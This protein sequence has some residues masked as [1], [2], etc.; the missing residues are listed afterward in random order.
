YVWNAIASNL[1]AS[2][3][4]LPSI[5]S[6]IEGCLRFVDKVKHGLG[7]NNLRWLRYVVL[8]LMGRT[9]SAESMG[10]EAFDEPS[11][12]RRLIAEGIAMAKHSYWSDK[13]ELL[14]ILGRYEEALSV[15]WLARPGADA[16]IGA[17]AHIT[18]HHV[19]GSLVLAAVYADQ[20]AVE[21]QRT[22][23]ILRQNL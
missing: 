22:L 6:E 20:G 23:W 14:F 5:L 1:L 17:M 21:K 9:P 16:A 2:G 19:Y 15:Y 12:E 10:G 3:Y 18:K 7:M 13:L 11:Y 4:E 8:M